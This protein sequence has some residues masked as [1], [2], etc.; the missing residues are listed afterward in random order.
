MFFTKYILFSEKIFLYETKNYMQKKKITEKNSFQ[1]KTFYTENICVTNENIYLFE[2]YNHSAKKNFFDHK[3][4]YL[5]KLRGELCNLVFQVS[6][7]PNL[8][9]FLN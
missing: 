1:E 6:E 2:L 5:L 4:I 3:K 7:A 9:Y 8:W